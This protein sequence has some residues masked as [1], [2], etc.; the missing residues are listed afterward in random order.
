MYPLLFSRYT[1]CKPSMRTFRLLSQL[2]ALIPLYRAVL[3]ASKQH[4]S[5]N[6]SCQYIQKTRFLLFFH[7]L[8]M[9]QGIP[10]ETRHLLT[11]LM[12][13]YG[14]VALVATRVI[15]L[16]LFHP[17]RSIPGPRLAKITSLWHLY[18]CLGGRRHR[19]LAELHTRYGNSKLDITLP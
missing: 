17:L 13:L 14:V 6:F 9:I 10:N 7:L 5:T 3:S 1:L 15:W 11:P 4:H 2:K 8:A 12:L 19:K 18:H 16:F